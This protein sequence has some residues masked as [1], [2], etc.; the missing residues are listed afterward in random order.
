MIISIE[1]NIGSG[2]S[3]ILNLLRNKYKGNE[4]VVFVDEPVSEWNEVKDGEKSI[5]ELFYN[6]KEKYSFAFQ[7]LAYITR[8]RKLLEALDG[9]IEKTIICERSIFT[10]KFVFA[11][12]LYQQNFINEIE[13]KSYNYW[14]DTFK[15]KTKLDRIIYI[16]TDPNICLERIKKRNRDGE[17]DISLEY[18]NHCH[19]LHQDWL[20]NENQNKVIEFNGNNN[21]DGI[22]EERY[23]KKIYEEIKI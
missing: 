14:F 4:N 22:N 8:L 12:M 16:N 7:I 1:G 17:S 13:W 5:L 6:D 2:K 18:L 19:L 10:D 9:P 20:I 15:E 23:V 11:K 3:T 21:F